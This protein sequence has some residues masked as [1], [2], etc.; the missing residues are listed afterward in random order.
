LKYSAEPLSPATV[1]LTFGGIADSE[2]HVT[3][4]LNISLAL[5]TVNSSPR[6]VKTVT[7][8]FFTPDS[9]PFDDNCVLL[10]ARLL[11]QLHLAVRPCDGSPQLIHVTHLPSGD[12]K[13]APVAPLDSDSLTSVALAVDTGDEDHD[14]S[15]DDPR[16]MKVV[17]SSSPSKLGVINIFFLW[18]LSLLCGL[19][20]S[21]LFIPLGTQ[22][23]G[24]DF[25]M[26][27]GIVEDNQSAFALSRHGLPTLELP[28]SRVDSL[29]AIHALEE[30]AD[31]IL[32]S[33]GNA[34]D[35]MVTGNA[36]CLLTDGAGARTPLAYAVTLNPSL[37]LL[38]DERLR[39]L[40]SKQLGPSEPKHNSLSNYVNSMHV[41]DSVLEHKTVNG[42]LYY[43]VRWDGSDKE[44][45]SW[46]PME[47][48][49]GTQALEDY[50][51]SQKK[52]S[53]A[54]PEFLMTSFPQPNLL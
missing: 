39:D 6:V 8:I 34:S 23:S 28:P 36:P 35:A 25:G 10:G 4:S 11:G 13:V 42:R 9:L 2:L 51:V 16:A 5:P 41:V 17:T 27:R 44:D 50:P 24:L 31:N 21:S 18:V 53:V 48:L 43:L 52:G 19:T 3:R 37:D 7:T 54:K 29:C 14:I 22:V 45:D 32:P 20:I 47:H 38:M 26:V 40:S 1:D 46:T 33:F 12:S 49:R 15:T 30:K